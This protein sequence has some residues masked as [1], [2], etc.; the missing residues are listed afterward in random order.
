LVCILVS[1]QDGLRFIVNAGL[2][3]I[4]KSRFG[5]LTPQ[6]LKTVDLLE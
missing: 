3:E 5:I 2:L 4:L 1:Q 6:I